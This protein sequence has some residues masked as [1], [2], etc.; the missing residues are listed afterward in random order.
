MIQYTTYL[1]YNCIIQFILSTMFCILINVFNGNALL[2][3]TLLISNF[4]YLL[5]S[6]CLLIIWM[7]IS[8]KNIY[9]V[10]DIPS[11]LKLLLYIL[12]TCSHLL[13]FVCIV[14]SVAM[15]SSKD[16]YSEIY[17]IVYISF[18]Q[19]I[20]GTL[21]YG[22]LIKKINNRIN[23]VINMFNTDVQYQGL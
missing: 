2:N 7:L 20:V 19:Q 8:N 15:E 13:S 5:I 23:N 18:I 10:T 6:L 9:S 12:L 22:I 14:I 16:K 4:L 1:L 3:T 21:I 17:I 11:Q